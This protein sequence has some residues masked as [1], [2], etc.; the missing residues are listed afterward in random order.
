[1]PFFH[2]RKSFEH[3]REVRAVYHEPEAASSG[4]Y[5]GVYVPL[6]LNNLIEKIYI[7]PTAPVWFAELV[8]SLCTTYNLNKEVVQSSLFSGPIY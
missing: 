6:D 3:E 2:K 1:M 8:S 5:G 4:S 7:C